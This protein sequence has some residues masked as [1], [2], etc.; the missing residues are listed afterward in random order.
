[1]LGNHYNTASARLYQASGDAETAS[2]DLS[3]PTTLCLRRQG[4][5]EY[6][7]AR[8]LSKGAKITRERRHRSYEPFLHSV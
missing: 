4:A 7:L 1:M 3:I 8:F 6:N 2:K 5:R